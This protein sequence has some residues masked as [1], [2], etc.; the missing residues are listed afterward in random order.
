M[1]PQPGQRYYYF[2]KYYQLKRDLDFRKTFLF[3]G[4]EMIQFLFNMP[5][6]EFILRYRLDQGEYAHYQSS[7]APKKY[8]NFIDY[9]C[10]RETGD[11]RY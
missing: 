2:E 8:Y 6:K 1:S 9:C 5:P 4:T 11:I 7:L 10:K 3:C